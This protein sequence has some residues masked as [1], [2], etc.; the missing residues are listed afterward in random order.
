MKIVVDLDICQR[1]GRCCMLAPQV[2][3]LDDA[4]LLTYQ[5]TTD[6][7]L[8]DAVDQAAEACPTQAIQ[9]LE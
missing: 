4:G 7:E 3:E 1:H 8:R 2:F 6:D 5:G 9:V